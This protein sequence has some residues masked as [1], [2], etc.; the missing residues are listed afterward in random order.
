MS[1]ESGYIYIYQLFNIITLFFF[2]LSKVCNVFCLFESLVLLL[3]STFV[4]S[5]YATIWC[6]CVLIGI[7][8]T[9]CNRLHIWFNDVCTNVT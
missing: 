7:S 4:S 9:V 5:S 3:S 2:S 1:K 6:I 8:K